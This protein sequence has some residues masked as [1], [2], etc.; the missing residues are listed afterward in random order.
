MVVTFFGHR[1]APESVRPHLEEAIRGLIVRG[2]T[3]FYVG[4]QGAFDR[5]ALGI[6][7][8]CQKENPGIRVLL[9]LA[10]RPAV[11][12]PIP[13]G[14]ETVYPLAD[15][16]PRFAI[17]RRNRWMIGRADVVISYVVHSFGGADKYTK[18]A[19]REGKEI[20]RISEN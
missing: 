2:A 13:D 6:L 16:V 17:D 19:E 8:A 7:S 9:V 11:G 5:M 15:G 14:V 20:V 4:N 18:I 1:D 12:S 3:L 10:Y